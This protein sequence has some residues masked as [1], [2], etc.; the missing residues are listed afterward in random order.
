M[1]KVN[2]IA[3]VVIGMISTVGVAFTGLNINHDHSTQPE[4]ILGHSGGTDA[5][6]CHTNHKTGNYHCHNPK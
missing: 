1:K 2:I 3:F 6:G 4:S 5:Y